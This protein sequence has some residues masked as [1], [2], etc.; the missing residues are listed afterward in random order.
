MLVLAA[1]GE[2]AVGIGH[3]LLELFLEGQGSFRCGGLLRFGTG[4][5]RTALRLRCALDGEA[6]LSGL[7]NADDLDA[8]GVPLRQ[9]RTDVADV[10]AGNLRDVHHAG[11]VF[12]QE[13]ER[14]EL[15]NAF[16]FSVS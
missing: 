1:A 5:G 2:L 14:A 9:M 4:T 10:G 15:C 8:D 13:D 3:E 16:D 7:V 11:A 6:D 12:R